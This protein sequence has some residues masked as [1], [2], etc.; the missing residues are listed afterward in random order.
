MGPKASTAQGSEYA[1]LLRDYDIVKT[2]DSDGLF[3]LKSKVNGGDYLLR[4]F[5]FNDKK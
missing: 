4:E 3:Y 1:A 2:L 5:T